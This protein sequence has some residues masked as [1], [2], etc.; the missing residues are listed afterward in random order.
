MSEREPA[1][2]RAIATL[3][4]LGAVGRPFNGCPERAQ[5]IRF[6]VVGDERA[7]TFTA[8][9]AQ[10][11]WMA[12]GIIGGAWCRRAPRRGRGRSWPR[13]TAAIAARTPARTYRASV[14]ECRIDPLK[15]GE[16]TMTAPEWPD[17]HFTVTPERAMEFLSLRNRD[18]VQVTV[19][20]GGDGAEAFWHVARAN[21]ATPRNAA[22]FPH[23]F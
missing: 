14:S 21:G 3:D 8:T 7:K 10:A 4:K 12:G 2:S 16:F 11:P 20:P 6:C 15:G 17:M 5:I 13:L 18:V 1:A 23:G 9:A 19:T 22:D